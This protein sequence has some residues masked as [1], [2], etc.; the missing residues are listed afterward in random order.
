M[1]V[2]DEQAFIEGGIEVLSHKG[3][4]V[5]AEVNGDLVI[6]R[7]HKERPQ[8]V[9]L[10][11]KLPSNGQEGL[12]KGLSI[13]SNIKEQQKQG[14]IDP[15]LRI[16]LVT[17][18]YVEDSGQ[19]LGLR[20]GAHAYL[21]K[22]ITF[23]LL[24]AHINAQ[25]KESENIK[26]MLEGS[27]RPA[28]SVPSLVFN[29]IS[30]DTSK[31]EVTVDGKK[32]FSPPRRLFDI[33]YFL[34]THAGEAKTKKEIFEEVW[35]FS[36][37]DESNLVTSIADLRNSLDEKNKKRFIETRPRYGYIFVSPKE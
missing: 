3:Y 26:S 2:D 10:D 27:G 34:A 17:G 1:L 13:C 29:G 14:V 7:I 20:L 16:I 8:V 36:D 24:A 32:T 25:L 11:I 28:S 22:P 35:G 19:I 5:V 15:A 33:L 6:D 31:R 37:V 30:I 21:S 4:D 12:T 18:E 23:D 9:V